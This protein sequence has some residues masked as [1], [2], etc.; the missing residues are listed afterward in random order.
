MAAELGTVRP[1]DDP[2]RDIAVALQDAKAAHRE[3]RLEHAERGYRSV[4]AAQQDNPDAL[5]LLGLVA[6]QR[7]QGQQAV[8]LIE[9]AIAVAPNNADFHFNLGKVH[10]LQGHPD[11]AIPCYER[12]HRLAPKN[13]G[14]LL[15]LGNCW[16]LRGD[17]RRAE[18]CYRMALTLD[19]NHLAALNNMGTLCRGEGRLE[20]AEVFYRRALQVDE[21]SPAVWENLAKTLTD[22]DRLQEAADAYR[23]TLKLDDSRETALHMLAAIE[24]RT[25][26]GAPEAYV[27]GLFDDYAGRF[28]KHLV[29][30]LGYS[31]PTLMRS[32]LDGECPGPGA[33]LDKAL[34]LGCGTGLAG[35]ALRQKIGWLQ[36]VDLSPK[37]LGEARQKA[38][39]DEL[40]E[41]EALTFLIATPTASWDLIVAADVLIYVG[42]LERLIPEVGRG[43]K[44]G[45]RF[46]LSVEQHDEGDE[47]YVLRSSGRYAHSK[48]YVMELA[49]RAGL[50][51]TLCRAV[52]LR[53][54]GAETLNGLLI[55]LT[56]A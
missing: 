10:K 13:P 51:E 24:G 17:M 11:L 14:T 4:L 47:G 15:N 36:G 34:D 18:R 55:A 1:I 5:H 31:I 33:T 54:N 43:L 9:R 56:R 41:A 22:R 45:G 44:P 3:G 42:D 8:S 21:T 46:L 40:T 52:P 12:A 25:T 6:Y 23:R 37:M 32:W 35:V 49:A 50:T 26:K 29:G 38:V 53:K 30:D 48:A 16:R 19:H 7:G 27:R 20:E 28:E 39:Y 2:R